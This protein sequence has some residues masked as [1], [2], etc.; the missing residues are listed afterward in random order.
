[1]VR[2]DSNVVVKLHIYKELTKELKFTVEV[3]IMRAKKIIFSVVC[4]AMLLCTMSLTVVNAMNKDDTVSPMSIMTYGPETKFW[5]SY[6]LV[7]FGQDGYD[8]TRVI[9][10]S[11]AKTKITAG[12]GRWDLNKTI[13]YQDADD[14]DVVDPSGY[15]EVKIPQYTGTTKFLYL[16]TADIFATTSPNTLIHVISLK[17]EY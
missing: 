10:N 4:I 8:H 12:V 1:M 9:N 11:K 15:I 13:L 14:Q 5:D 6:V 2:G 7:A 17:K 16:H 3:K